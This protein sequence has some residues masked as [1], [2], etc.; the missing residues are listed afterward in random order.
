MTSID[1]LCMSVT[2]SS[3]TPTQGIFYDDKIWSSGF[4]DVTSL[5]L[6]EDSLLF[7]CIVASEEGFAST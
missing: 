3:T 5:D 2:F 4:L 7:S 1:S 6:V